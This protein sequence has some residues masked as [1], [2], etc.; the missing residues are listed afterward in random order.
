MTTENSYQTPDPVQ[1][2]LDKQL[3]HLKTLY[4]VS[5]ELLGLTDVSMILRN[6]LLIPLQ[7]KSLT[8]NPSASRKRNARLSKA[9]AKQL[10]PRNFSAVS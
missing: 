1:A 9:L 7:G 3:F 5:H 8:L 10:S 4:D 6:F 2:E